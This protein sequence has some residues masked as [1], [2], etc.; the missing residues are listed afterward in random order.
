MTEKQHANDVHVVHVAPTIDSTFSW[1]D[2]KYG[3]GTDAKEKEILKLI[4]QRDAAQAGGGGGG[5]GPRS[6]G[7]KDA[8]ALEEQVAEMEDELY[9]LKQQ[10]EEEQDRA[11]DLEK[12]LRSQGMQELQMELEDMR[13]AKER[14]EAM[15]DN[16]CS[17]GYAGSKKAMGR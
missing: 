13:A 8:S 14:A 5:G 7:G 6:P 3:V 12:E 16:F 9:S 17:D 4:Q 15:L 10:L 11:A 2:V 1:A